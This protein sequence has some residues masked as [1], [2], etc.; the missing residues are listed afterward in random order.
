MHTLTR[1][2]GPVVKMLDSFMNPSAN[3]N[4]DF[5][6][7]KDLVIDSFKMMAYSFA[8]KGKKE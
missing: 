6:Q 4:E 8:A 3:V 7:V 5:K 1:C 2:L